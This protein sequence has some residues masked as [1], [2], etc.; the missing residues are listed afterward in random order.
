[1]ASFRSFRN[2]IA[3]PGTVAVSL[4]NGSQENDWVLISIQNGDSGSTVTIDSGVTVLYSG[5]MGT[6]KI[7]YGKKQLTSTDIANGSL[8]VTLSGTTN[9][10]R[11][12]IV[13]FYDCLGF[14]AP[15]TMTFRSG[16]S[17]TIT[18][19]ATTATSA[20]RVVVLR[21]EKSTNNPGPAAVSPPLT[22]LAQW[23]SNA[24]AAQSYYVGW[25][26][27]P[28]VTRTFTDSVSS[29]NGMGVQI[30]ITEPVTVAPTYKISVWDGTTEITNATASLWDGTDEVAI[31]SVE[32]V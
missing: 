24:A 11:V 9:S 12:F 10:S 1:M 25:Y 13:G 21:F 22:T 18:A 6:A 17:N 14:D 7:A 23:Y 26:Q 32:T 28:G 31:T 2:S 4:P 30:A 20:Q 15:G 3:A 19:L 27:G 16:I 8:S 29:G 5:V